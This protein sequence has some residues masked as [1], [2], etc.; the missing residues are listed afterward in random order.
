MVIVKL[1]NH[2]K[3]FFK[4]YNFLNPKQSLKVLFSLLLKNVENWSVQ[5]AIVWVFCLNVSES[6]WEI[7][8]HFVLI[9]DH[10]LEVVICFDSDN[11]FRI[12]N[13]NLL[14]QTIIFKNK[15]LSEFLLFLLIH[16]NL[17]WFQ[18]LLISHDNKNCDS[19]YSS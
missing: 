7:V 17:P 13:M 3:Y 9:Y 1:L 18:M 6:W 14:C 12:S 11:T 16:H 19:F 15:I 8:C 2:F 4:Q 10:S 5:F